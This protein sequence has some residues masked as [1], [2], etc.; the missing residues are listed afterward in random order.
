MWPLAGY[1]RKY[2]KD[3]LRSQV[4]DATSNLI[5][6]YDPVQGLLYNKSD[7][8]VQGLLYNKSDVQIPSQ[9]KLNLSKVYI[10]ITTSTC[11]PYQ[12]SIFHLNG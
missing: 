6:P 12:D 10:W 1:L 9:Y 5:E 2:K 7:A 8:Q 3:F 11:E 4:N